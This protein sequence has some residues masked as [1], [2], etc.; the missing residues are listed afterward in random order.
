MSLYNLEDRIPFNPETIWKET[1]Q[2]H[3][4]EGE[5][6]LR[7]PVPTRALP[8]RIPTAAE[9]LKRRGRPSKT[10]CEY[11]FFFAYKDIAG[12][13]AN[14]LPT[15]GNLFANVSDH[16]GQGPTNTS[17]QKTEKSHHQIFTQYSLCMPVGLRAGWP[18]SQASWPK[19]PTGPAGW[20][21]WPA[22]RVGRP[23]GRAGWTSQLGQKLVNT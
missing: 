2:R 8:T 6:P 4:L 13:T 9:R 17:C 7:A 5:F 11:S 3:R 22:G 18:R 15:L 23:A 1:S 10:C 21:S 16:V 20:P 19:W 14:M 12:A